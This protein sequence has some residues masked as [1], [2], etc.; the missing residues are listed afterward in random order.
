MKL[1]VVMKRPGNVNKKPTWQLRIEG[2][3]AIPLKCS[4]DT[5]PIG[6]DVIDAIR[7]HYDPALL[8]MT[9]H[10]I[11]ENMVLEAPRT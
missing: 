5:K 7:G 4:G 3:H 6:Q 9:D 1:T 11:L 2:Y 8:A 10:E